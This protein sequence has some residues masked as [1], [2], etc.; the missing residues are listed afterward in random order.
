MSFQTFHRILLI[1]YTVCRNA[2]L[3]KISS[4]SGKKIDFQP[5]GAEKKRRRAPRNSQKPFISLICGV[6]KKNVPLVSRGN[7]ARAQDAVGARLWELSSQSS[8][9][10]N[11][12]VQ[13][14]SKR[15][16]RGAI[17]VA[18]AWMDGSYIIPRVGSRVLWVRQAH[19]QPGSSFFW[20]FLL[21]W[22]N[23]WWSGDRRR[24]L[25]LSPRSRDTDRTRAANDSAAAAQC[26]RWHWPRI[27]NA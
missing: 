4:Q 12:S 8:R 19:K 14:K 11:T 10:L 16:N 1:S 9:R 23:S 24:S 2:S 20:S 7:C 3:P 6:V 22:K 17:W 26:Q 27:R 18:G 15:N 25:S 13:T 5:K 21:V